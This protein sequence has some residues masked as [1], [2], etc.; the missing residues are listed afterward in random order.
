MYKNP[1]AFRDIVSGSNGA[2][3]AKQGWDACTGLGTPN[4]DLI[5]QVLAGGSVFPTATLRWTVP[6]VRADGTLLPAAEVAGADVYDTPTPQPSMAPIGSVVGTVGT[7]VTGP[8]KP[9][10]HTFTVMTRDTAG[11]KSPTSNDATCTIRPAAPPAAIT[12]LTVTINP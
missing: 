10:I 2:Y 11:N 3:A 7:F 12:D 1:T 6:T 9:G 4:G 5:Q 8:L